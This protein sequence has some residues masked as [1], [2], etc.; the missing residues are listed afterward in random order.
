[1]FAFTTGRCLSLESPIS[2][3]RT[4]SGARLNTNSQARIEITTF[5]VCFIPSPALLTANPP[6][7]ACRGQ[8][9]G[10]ARRPKSR[11]CGFCD[12]VF[13]PI[14]IWILTGY[15]M[16]AWGDCWRFLG[17]YLRKNGGFRVDG[18]MDWWVSST[19]TAGEKASLVK[20]ITKP[21]C[22][23]WTPALA[24]VEVAIHNPACSKFHECHSSSNWPVGVRSRL[25]FK[26]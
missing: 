8:F 6:D 21:S 23:R 20:K 26:D 10:I 4:R 25:Q 12:L 14:T 15:E 22:P 7:S 5:A 19:V 9:K 16:T 24:F 2:K 18:W 17:D 11:A 1:M 3:S 13:V